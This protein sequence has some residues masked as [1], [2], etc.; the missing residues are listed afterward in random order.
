MQ[1]TLRYFAAIREGLGLASEPWQTQV[2]TLG[3]L[4]LELASRN[5]LYGA[6]LGHQQVLRMAINQ[7]MATEEVVLTD[8][9]EVAFFP[10]VTGG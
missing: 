1:L 5:A 3:E 6:H 4:R 2:Q 7:V 10:P 9:A 8:Q